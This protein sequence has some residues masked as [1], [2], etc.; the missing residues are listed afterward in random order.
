MSSEQAPV[1]AARGLGKCYRLYDRPGQRMA[2]LLTGGWRQRGRPFWALRGLDLA[3]ARGETVGIVG[4]N[5]AGK[6][7]LLQLVCGTLTPTEGTLAVRGRVAALLELGAGFHPDYSG[8]ENARLNAAL[9]GLSTGEIDARLQ[10]IIDFAEIGAFIDQPVKHYSSGMF[11]RLA[12]AVATAVQPDVLV[13]DEALSVGDG[14]FARKSFDRIMALRERGATVLFCSHSMYQVEVLCTRALWIDG[15]QVRMD[16][17]AGEVAAA[18]QASLNAQA[19]PTAATATLAARWRAAPAGGGAIVQVRPRVNGRPV[20]GGADAEPVLRCG[21]D[22]LALD[23][24]YVSDPALP[25]PTLAI[26]LSDA[27][28]LT[29]SSASS[30]HD[31]AVLWRDAQGR[32]QARLEFPA[33]PLLQGRYTLTPFLLC[34][35]ATHIYDQV[36]DAVR[37]RVVDDSPEQGLVRLPHRWLARDPEALPG[38]PGGLAPHTLHLAGRALTLR[39]VHAGDAPAVVALH[40]RV[41]GSDADAD[42]FAWKYVAGEGLAV[43]LWDE[44]AAGPVPTLLAFC[45][46]LPRRLHAAGAVHA[47]LQIGD[48]MVDPAWRGL[49]T[50]RGAFFQ[51]SDALY[52]HALGPQ[53]AHDWGF[54]FP[55]ARHLQLAVKLGLLHDASAMQQLSW[56]PAPAADGAGPPH[57]LDPAAPEWVRA[58][59]R[60]W[61]AMCAEAGP[62]VLGERGPHWLHWRHVQRPGAAS[63]FLAVTDV[64][65][66]PPGVLVLS[67]PGPR[68][69]WL[70]WVGPA[71]GLGAALAAARDDAARHGAGELWAWTS[72]ALAAALTAASPPSARPQTTEVARIGVP[73]ASTLDAAAAAATPWWWWGG[74]TDFL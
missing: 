29:V 72:P 68:V 33:L 38:E 58:V 67:A 12:F 50:R 25:A 32:G 6:S 30:R 41:F 9:L 60:A 15:G 37:I 51:V 14:A 20:V 26:G 10:E 47:G 34:E 49:L 65:G 18:Y 42:W 62:R 48:V 36:Q 61:A 39:S 13:I 56:T 71:A 44:A 73:C 43:G 5:G 21:Q 53:R 28:R 3:L 2:D 40:R 57:A 52:R 24:D 70:D 55:S 27:A 16:G 19:A 7:T 11:M 23:I 1:I 22:T 8:R 4:R 63:R 46:G 64:A 31:G 17:P 59:D 69:Q 35:Q 54:G 74:D 66:G 45:G